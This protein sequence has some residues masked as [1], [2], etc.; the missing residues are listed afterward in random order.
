MRRRTLWR[1]SWRRACRKGLLR[2]TKQGK[3][4]GHVT[5]IKHDRTTINYTCEWYAN[6]RI[7]WYT[8]LTSNVV[9]QRFDKNSSEA[10]LFWAAPTYIVTSSGQFCRPLTAFA[11]WELQMLRSIYQGDAGWYTLVQHCT[12]TPSIPTFWS[13]RGAWLRSELCF[14]IGKIPRVTVFVLALWER[15]LRVWPS[16]STKLNWTDAG[17]ESEAAARNWD[18]GRRVFCFIV[19][20]CIRSSKIIWVSSEDRT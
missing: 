11:R 5:S 3:L 6:H 12:A 1:L 10:S 7:Q 8:V 18:S 16:R 4:L 20:L 2:W 14:A 9:W 13:I 15:S 17:S 19:I